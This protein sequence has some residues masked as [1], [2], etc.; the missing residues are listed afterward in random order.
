[1]KIPANTE[2]LLEYYLFVN[3]IYVCMIVS[4]SVLVRINLILMHPYIEYYIHTYE[5][6]REISYQ[7]ILTC[8]NVFVYFCIL[9]TV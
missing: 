2:Y 1:M 8:N 5:R 7:C 9:R 6:E 3:F 4:I